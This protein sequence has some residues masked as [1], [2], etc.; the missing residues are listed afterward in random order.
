MSSSGVSSDSDFSVVKIDE[1]IGNVTYIAKI[2]G[3]NAKAWSILRIINTNG[4]TELSTARPS[5]NASFANV[6]EAFT[7]RVNLVY[8]V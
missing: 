6:N 5:V 7:N 2:Y 8:A 3:G 1:S 4:I